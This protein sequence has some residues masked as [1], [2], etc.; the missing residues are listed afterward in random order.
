MP[1][2]MVFTSF[3]LHALPEQYTLFGLKSAVQKATSKAVYD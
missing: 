1:G 2:A 3:P